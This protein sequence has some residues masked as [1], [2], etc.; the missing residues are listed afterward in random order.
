LYLPQAKTFIGCAAL[1][2]GILVSSRPLPRTT[3]I[4][5]EIRR[6]GAAVFGGSTRI[7]GMRKPLRSLVDYLYR[8]NS[9]PVGCLL[10]T[11][12]GIVPPGR[13]SLRRGDEVRITIA[14]IGTL[15]N[16]MA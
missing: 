13:F 2:P 3:S 7:S 11:G 16:T 1:G 8:D 15:V 4:A 5:I 14:P 10:M 9:F 6:R 12:T